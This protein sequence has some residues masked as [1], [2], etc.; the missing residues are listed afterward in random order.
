M[1][2]LRV[3]T[4]LRWCQMAERLRPSGFEPAGRVFDSP[5]A[6]YAGRALRGGG[7]ISKNP[8][9]ARTVPRVCLTKASYGEG[10]L[11]AGLELR[12][13]PPS[14]VP[15]KGL[16]RLAVIITFSVLT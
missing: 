15:T 16:A 10:R 3:A 14:D 7:D 4:G 1:L 13:G 6:R 9:C 11:R 12:R 2:S 5:R 8:D